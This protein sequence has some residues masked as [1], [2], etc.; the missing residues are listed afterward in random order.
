MLSANGWSL[1]INHQSLLPIARR[2]NQLLEKI[3]EFGKFEIY[4]N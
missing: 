3:H 1:S 2:V 4:L